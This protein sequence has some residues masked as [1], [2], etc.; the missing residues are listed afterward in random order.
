MYVHAPPTQLTLPMV[1][2]LLAHLKSYVH[3]SGTF[4]WNTHKPQQTE[5]HSIYFFTT[6]G[7][8]ALKLRQDPADQ[9]NP[10]QLMTT[11]SNLTHADR[12]WVKFRVPLGCPIQEITL[13]MHRRLRGLDVE[14]LRLLMCGIFEI[15]VDD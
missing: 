7:N 1:L 12:D 13:D 2:S 4:C 8:D 9:P 14:E 6:P 11:R 10:I 15:D 3:M 5:I